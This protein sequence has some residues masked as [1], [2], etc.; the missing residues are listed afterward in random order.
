MV[1]IR[2][3]V[4]YQFIMIIVGKHRLCKLSDSVLFLNQQSGY[5][6]DYKNDL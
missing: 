1:I 3:D 6:R 5:T 2:I 4:V